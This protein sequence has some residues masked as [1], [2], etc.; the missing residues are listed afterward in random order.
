MDFMHHEEYFLPGK[1]ALGKGYLWPSLGC[2]SHTQD[3]GGVPRIWN[4][5]SL[6]PSEDETMKDFSRKKSKKKMGNNI[7]LILPGKTRS[8]SSS[9]RDPTPGTAI[10]VFYFY[11]TAEG[12]RKLLVQ[13]KYYQITQGFCFNL[14][15]F[16][17]L[18][19]KINFQAGLLW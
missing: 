16:L 17:Y 3:T 18:K 19:N 4:F 14:L 10:L 1:A 12:W 11:W 6:L 8:K 7:P 15:L 5:F 13:S 9:Q 2:L